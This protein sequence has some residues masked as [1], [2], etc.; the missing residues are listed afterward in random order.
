MKGHVRA[1]GKSWEIRWHDVAGH[2]RT[3][4]IR[5]TKAQADQ[6]LREELSRVDRG[7]EHVKKTRTTVAQWVAE[8]IEAW[9]AK[10]NHR[11]F[12]GEL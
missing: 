10:G 4:A 9:H 8:R 6:A 5:G 3:R 2:Q 7:E 12:Q 11:S 1:R